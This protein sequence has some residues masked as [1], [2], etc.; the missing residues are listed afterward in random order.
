MNIFIVST[1]RLKYTFI[2]IYIYIYIYIYMNVHIHVYIIVFQ[3]IFLKFINKGTKGKFK[4]GNIFLNL[5]IFSQR[6]N[7]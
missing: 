7:K 4:I 3:D 2:F 6:K 1:C 5:F